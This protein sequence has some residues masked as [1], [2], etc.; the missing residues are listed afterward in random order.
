LHAAGD[1]VANA[2]TISGAKSDVAATSSSSNVVIK[3]MA[4]KDFPALTDHWKKS[5]MAEADRSAYHNVSWLLGGV[6][7]FVPDL[8]FLM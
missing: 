4:K 8:E 5:T 2:K 1:V 6:G 3:K 7:S